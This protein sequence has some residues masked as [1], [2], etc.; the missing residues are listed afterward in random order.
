M[1]QNLGQGEVS[2]KS[3]GTAFILSFFLGGMGIDRFYRGQV[4]FGILKLIT[5]GGLGIWAFIDTLILGIGAATDSQ[6]R[7]LRREAPV[8]NPV[9]SQSA[10]FLLAYFLGYLGVDQFYLGNVGLGIVKLL[11]CGGFGIWWLVDVIIIG[12]GSRKDS[13][14]NSL[15]V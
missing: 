9:K 5:C 15:R 1:M 4:L 2:P 12:M 10:A 3:H 13:N 6:G 7:M 14:G 8:G 11:T